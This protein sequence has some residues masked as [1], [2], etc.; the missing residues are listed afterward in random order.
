VVDEGDILAARDELARQ[1]LFVEPT[2]AV[3][4]PAFR[5]IVGRMPDP[6]VTL[7]TGS[8]LKYRENS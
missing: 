1:G 2:S 4:L 8:G 6:I 7:L 5:Q 3:V